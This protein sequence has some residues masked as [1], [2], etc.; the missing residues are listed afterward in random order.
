M[1]FHI[2][3]P[4]WTEASQKIK[5]CDWAQRLV[6]AMKQDVLNWSEVSIIP[7][8]DRLSGWLHNYFCDQSGQALIFDPAN[9]YKHRSPNGKI[10]TGEKYDAAWVSLVHNNNAVHLERCAIL[11]K[12]GICPEL[13]RKEII[14]L[15]TS[16]SEIYPEYNSHGKWIPAKLMPQTLDEALW[17]ISFLRAIRWSGIAD[18]LSANTLDN[19]SRMAQMVIE[20]LSKSRL[21]ISNIRCWELAGMAECAYW[22]NDKDLLESCWN[23]KSGMAPQLEFGL[24]NDGIWFEGSIHYHF[25]A[26]TAILSFLDI[27]G[28]EHLLPHLQEKLKLAF[29]NPLK[30]AYS[31]GRL[32]AYNDGWPS[33]SVLDN[34]DIYESFY[35]MLPEQERN[36]SVYEF[37]RDGKPGR[38]RPYSRSFNPMYSY[39]LAKDLPPRRSTAA[40][41]FGSMKLP[42]TKNTSQSTLLAYSGISVLRNDKVRLALRFTPPGGGHDHRDE[43]SVDV[44]TNQGWFSLDCGTSGYGAKITSDWQRTGVAHNIV[45]IDGLSQQLSN[46]YL[47]KWTD[48][49]VCAECT[50]AYDGVTLRRSL[51]LQENGWIDD[52]E[53][54]S[55]TSHRIDWMFHG[56]GLF[57]PDE[58]ESITASFSGEKGFD[59][60]SEAKQI[61]PK[62]NT[63]SGY[64]KHEKIIQKI[65]LEIPD[66]F[67]F[68]CGKAPDNP[69]GRDSGIIILRGQ[70]ANTII[71]AHF[72][73]L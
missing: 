1:D 52:F 27:A 9:P 67:E 48:S 35:S 22:L 5:E 15:V 39:S 66:G 55:E 12:L 11:L 51:E 56:D 44:E 40:L 45:M 23:S 2:K 18:S 60:I 13:T 10:Y 34:A 57:F 73:D 25:Y 65:Q 41:L 64:W 38:M 43:L 50:G 20:L 72:S 69:N 54:L 53:I 42:E 46:G 24:N 32:P 49:S 7:G 19:I 33:V 8:P 59:M 30:L 21:N 29:E 3:Q 26:L 31:D 63:I 58:K 14:R 70:A 28:M 6:E 37:I 62:N 36:S 68:Y 16:Y 61:T 71:K 4:D 47:K 17:S